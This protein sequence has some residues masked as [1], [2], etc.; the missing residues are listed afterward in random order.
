MQRLYIVRRSKKV[1]SKT[2]NSELKTLWRLLKL[3]RPYW[4]WMALGIFI[5]LITLLSNVSLLALSGWF[6]TSMAI[7][8]VAGVSM[9]YFTPAATIRG[10]A[11]L[12]ITSRYGERVITHEA[13]FR[14]LAEL[15]TWLYSRLEPLAPAV[16]QTYKSGDLLSRIRA[17]IDT[18]ENF[19]IRILLPIVVA[20]IGTLLFVL[21]IFQY[22]PLLALVELVLLLIAGVLLPLV[23]MKLSKKPGKAII[24]TSSELRSSVVDSVQ[25]M[26]ELLIYGAAQRQTEKIMTLTDSLLA[27]QRQMAKYKGLS[28]AGLGFCANIAMWLVMVLAIPFMLQQS[29]SPASMVMLILFTLASFETVMPLPLAFQLLPETLAAAKR[30]FSIAD[31]QPVIDEPQTD[32][33]QPSHF[34]IEF[35]HVNFSYSTLS[36]SLASSAATKNTP[37]LTDF[38]LKISQGTKLGIVGASGSGK[39]TIVQLLLRFWPIDSGQISVGGY[40][41]DRY[42]SDDLRQY[43]SVVSQH[44]HLFNSTV[45][46]NLKMANREASDNMLEKACRI[47]HIHDFIMT[48]PDGYD[49]WIGEAG[50]KLSGGEARRL[51]IAR[52]LLKDAPILILDEP[53]EGLDPKLENDVL[54]SILLW[55]DTQNK[56]IIYITHKQLGLDSMDHVLKL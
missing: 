45:L 18:L 14:L 51:S 22:H 1:K 40:P 50:T 46:A 12:R 6:I 11:I 39:S 36:L 53:F 29:F 48:L 19:Y 35:S 21:F 38:N 31:A 34:D 37:V 42:V 4:G 47:A 30:I 16:L 54:N 15:R 52:A 28:Q 32:S 3:F 56:T 5:S 10:L 44:A 26:G 24:E 2:N 43:L 20:I 23:V 8:G 49:T 25:G 13:T 7:A 17:D 41:I 33:P 9:N 27:E 55:A